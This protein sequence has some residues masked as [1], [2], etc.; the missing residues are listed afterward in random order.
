MSLW[1]EDSSRSLVIPTLQEVQALQNNSSGEW[2]MHPALGEVK[3]WPKRCQ[4]GRS[5]S[6][7]FSEKMPDVP[8]PV[9][10]RPGRPEVSW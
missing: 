7:G 10:C 5:E 4:K 1:S 3:R 2:N 6:S 8:R 9:W